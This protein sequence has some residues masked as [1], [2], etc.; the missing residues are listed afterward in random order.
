MAEDKGQCYVPIHHRICLGVALL[1]LL[2]LVIIA[3]AVCVHI[4]RPSGELLGKFAVHLIVSCAVF[5]FSIFIYIYVSSSELYQAI[6]FDVVS[7][8]NSSS[9]CELNST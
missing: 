2:L 3:A 5:C 6:Y 8:C 4:F 1:F 9:K 7:S